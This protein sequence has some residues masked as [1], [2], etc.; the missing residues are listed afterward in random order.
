LGGG[1][2]DDGGYYRSDAAPYAESTAP[3]PVVVPAPLPPRRIGDDRPT[4]EHTD[5]G[6]TII[7]GPGLN[8]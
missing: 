1:F 2:Y 8:H 6:V 5:V 3:E 4:V 7:R